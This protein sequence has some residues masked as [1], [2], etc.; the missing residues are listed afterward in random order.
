M[1]CAYASL[2]WPTKLAH[3]YKA[4]LSEE[5]CL[6]SSNCIEGFF[7]GNS[8]SDKR[9]SRKSSFVLCSGLRTART[10]GYTGLYSS[11]VCSPS[12][13]EKLGF[14]LFDT[15]DLPNRAVAHSKV[16]LCLENVGV[17]R[18]V[19]GHCAKRCTSRKVA[20]LERI[21]GCYECKSTMLPRGINSKIDSKTEL[22][23]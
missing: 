18:P 12:F 9:A 17:C 20:A 6:Y 15:E 5:G 21:V 19:R 11:S 10:M 13:L 23:V 4:G 16:P 3:Y 7:L 1:W 2:L 22:P 14:R 8:V